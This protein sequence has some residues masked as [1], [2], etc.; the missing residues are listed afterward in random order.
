MKIVKKV[1]VTLLILLFLTAGSVFIVITFYKKEM[2][3]LLTD[4]LKE[5]YG[6]VLKADDVK[7]SFFSNWPN[8]SIEFR[9]IRI[10]NVLSAGNDA[11]LFNAGSVSL[12][13]NLEKLL[14]KEFIVKSVAVKDA[15]INL[16]RDEN[17]VKNFEFKKSDTLPSAKSSISFEIGKVSIQN[18]LFTFQNKQNGQ[19][20]EFVL[21]ENAIRLKH[22]ADGV[23]AGLT[24]NIF[25]KG[26]LFKKEKGAFLANSAAK[27]D[28]GA[29][30]CYPRKEI[31]IHAPSFVVIGR[32]KFD[33]SAFVELN[34]NKQLLLNI[35]TR[36]IGYSQGIALLNPGIKKALSNIKVSNPVN[37]KILLVAK[38]GIKQE[39]IIIVDLSGK[40]NNIIIGHSKIPYS[41]VSFNGQ[42]VSIDRSKTMGNSEEATVSFKPLKG[43]VYGLPF[44]GSVVI[45]N[46]VNPDIKINADL[47]ID[48]KNIPFKPG[49]EFILKGTAIANIHYAGPVNKMN[50]KEFLDAPMELK[51]NVK[52]NNV[53]YREK[54]KPVY[55][56][57]VNGTAFVTNNEL[58]FNNLLLKMNG[59]TLK[60]KGSV[61]NFVKYALGQTNGFKANLKASTDYFDLTSYVVKKNDTSAIETEKV[62]KINTIDQSK[63]EFD[64]FLA[65]KKLLIRKVDASNASINLHYKNNLL[66]LKSLNV[67]T[68]GGS[69]SAT[70]SIY[71]LHKINADI[72]MQNININKLFEQFEN[73][74]QK[75]IEGQNLQGNVFVNATLKTD[76]DENMEVIGKTIAAKVDLKLKDGHLLNY[77]PL[78]NISDYIFRNRDFKD[79]SFS[80]I[81]ETFVMDGFKM[82][83]QEME[84]ASNVLNLYMSGTYHFKEQSNIN[85]LLPWSNLK[86]RGKNYIP[87]S[88]GQTAENS[89]GLKLN[90]SGMP[91][92]LKLSLG[93]K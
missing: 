70:G 2:A 4:H 82:D 54:I 36:N 34:E 19:K 28:L 93:N 81:N 15:E 39:P 9:N 16:L 79:I 1:L 75:A 58:T 11:P 33:V 63:F 68:C 8:A 30:I 45:H 77:E 17:G 85:I 55:S 31:F 59:G 52:F 46:L 80:E 14:R 72:A 61:D 47:F 73:F 42:I 76:L 88:S 65:A 60:L 62:E 64:V 89:R 10:T 49:Q 50:Q 84:I 29:T 51:A 87:K 69:L 27:L 24:G 5:S 48:V 92:K 25:V 43:K 38:I 67:N 35:E 32:Q 57:L 13:F 66:D 26:L 37:A 6:L 12:S 90:Y 3:S 41:D 71:D 44:T 86:R 20:I 22:Y 21:K 18:T 56:Y 74:G 23:E 91:N 40:N 78:Q 83:I 7:V 53:S